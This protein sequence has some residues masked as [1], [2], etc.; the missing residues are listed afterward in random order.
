[1]KNGPYGYWHMTLIEP[2]KALWRWIVLQ[3]RGGK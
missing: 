3:M 2:I 1:M